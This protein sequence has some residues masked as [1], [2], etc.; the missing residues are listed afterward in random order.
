MPDGLNV[1]SGNFH[2]P[3]ESSANEPPT[4]A[5]NFASSDVLQ[6]EHTAQTVG[7]VA[8]DLPSECPTDPV[9]LAAPCV[10]GDLVEVPDLWQAITQDLPVS[11][12]SCGGLYRVAGNVHLLD[13]YTWSYEGSIPPELLSA[14]P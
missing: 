10:C 2:P 12:K 8:I 3:L 9:A 6:A 4:R 14:G 1:D 11:C 7:A 13:D 5:T